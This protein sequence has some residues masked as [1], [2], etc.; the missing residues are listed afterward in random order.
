MKVGLLLCA[1]SMGALRRLQVPPED[2]HSER[3]EA[4]LR[5]NMGGLLRR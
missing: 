1:P 4:R 2:G 5:K 3:S